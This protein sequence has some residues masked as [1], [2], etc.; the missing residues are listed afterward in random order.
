MSNKK[1]ATGI[2]I[3]AAVDN[4]SVIQSAKETAQNIA[5]SPQKAMSAYSSLTDGSEQSA[6]VASSLQELLSRQVTDSNSKPIESDKATELTNRVLSEKAESE[7]EQWLSKA[8]TTV[9]QEAE[10]TEQVVS[11]DIDKFNPVEEQTVLDSEHQSQSIERHQAESLLS[12]TNVIHAEFDSE[13]ASLKSELSS[14]KE[15]LQHQV[16]NLMWQDL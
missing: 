12:D 6:K 13:I 4:D 5:Q 15:L 7:F 2:E 16:S 3:V 8:R 10:S 1:T 14:I 9:T 11:Y